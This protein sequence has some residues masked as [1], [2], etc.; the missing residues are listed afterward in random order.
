METATCE[1]RRMCYEMLLMTRCV[2]GRKKSLQKDYPQLIV[3]KND[4]PTVEQI[5]EA[6]R[7]LDFMADHFIKGGYESKYHR[8]HGG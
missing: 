7:E 1:Y 4:V 8:C 2:F 5:K 6:E 3:K